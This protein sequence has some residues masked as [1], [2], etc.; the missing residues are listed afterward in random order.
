MADLISMIELVNFDHDSNVQFSDS[1]P[2]VYCKLLD[3]GQL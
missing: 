3:K 2:F 1:L